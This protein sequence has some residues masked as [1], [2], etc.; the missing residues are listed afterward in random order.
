[1]TAALRWAAV[2]AI[3]MT[4]VL[5]WAAVTNLFNVRLIVGDEVTKM[6]VADHNFLKRQVELERN[7]ELKSLCL[8]LTSLIVVP[9]GRTVSTDHTFRRDRNAEV[10]SN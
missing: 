6:V 7:D 5:R 4:S 1:M 3:L 2:R 9:L 10:E 8:P